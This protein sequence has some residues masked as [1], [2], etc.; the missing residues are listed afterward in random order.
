MTTAPAY[1]LPA[2]P[3]LRL[4]FTLQAEE[5]AVLPEFQG[6]MLRGAFGHSLRRLVC[7]LGPDQPCAACPLRRTCAYPRIFEPSRDGGPP[8]FLRG[9]D[10]VVRPYVFEPRSASGPLAPGG[11]LAFDLLLF[12]QA[13]ELQAYA[14][15][16]VQRMARAGLGKGRARF[17]LVQADAVDPALPPRPLF[18]EGAPLD[19][20]PAPPVTP[21]WEPLPG[22]SVTLRFVTPLRLKVRDRLTARP[23][24]RDLAFA[25]LRR[26]LELA[27][28]HVPEAPLDERFHPLLD[29][30]PEIRIPAADLSWRDQERWSQRQQTAMRLGGVVGT[31]RLEGDL[32]PF[33]PLL[34]TAELVHVG[35]GA[36]FGLGRMDVLP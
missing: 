18:A 19:V 7:V 25:M 32:T 35:K 26:T 4:R 12:G 1:S 36:T 29:Q 15:L 31:L 14:V 16:A 5:P 2:I 21:R 9:G 30:A 6:S 34:R 22:P 27:Y 28:A 17:R 3:Y 8:S 10:E 33:I 24:F 23:R 20:P 13:V 11:P